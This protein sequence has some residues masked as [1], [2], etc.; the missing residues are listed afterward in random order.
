MTWENTHNLS[1]GTVIPIEIMEATS[2]AARRHGL[3]IHLDGAR[4]FNAVAATGVP[5]DRFAASADT[6]QFCFSKGLGAPIGSIICGPADLMSEIRYLRKRVGGGM[7]QVG[8][9]A[10]AARV[11]LN[12]RDR[13]VDDHKVARGLGEGLAQLFPGA[14]DPM[15]VETNIVLV[16]FASLKL[17]W[18]EVNKRLTHAGIKANAPLPNGWRLVTHQDVDLS[19]VGRLL[20]CLQ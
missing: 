19:D 5:A 6:I 12:G 16:D 4:I 20:D 7:R 18:D 14:V 17:S 2:A 11:A 15:T 9:L 1:G 13:L 8:V 3:K 10:A